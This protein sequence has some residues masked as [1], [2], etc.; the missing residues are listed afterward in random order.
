PKTD[1]FGAE[2]TVTVV[3]ALLTVR[4]VEAPLSRCTDDAGKFAPIVSVPAEVG[5]TLTEQVETPAAPGTSRQLEP[6]RPAPV[7][8][9]VPVGEIAVPLP[10]V[11][12]TVTVTDVV[13]PTT[14]G[15]APKAI[16]VALVRPLTVRLK[17]CVAFCGVP[18]VESTTWTVKTNDPEADADPA[19]TPTADRVSPAASEQPEARHPLRGASP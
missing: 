9:I 16:D 14:T 5:V 3:A 15:F 18:A 10:C 12:V 17:V 19:I 6:E 7:S 8:E 11:S 13:C 4:P 1:G 2:V